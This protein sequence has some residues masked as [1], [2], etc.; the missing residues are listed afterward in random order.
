[1]GNNRGCCYGKK[2]VEETWAVV[3]DTQ[4]HK[5]MRLTLLLIE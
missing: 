3:L 4:I 5:G 1:M 2:A